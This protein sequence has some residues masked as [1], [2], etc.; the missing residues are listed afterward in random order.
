VAAAIDRVFVLLFCVLFVA[1]LLQMLTYLV[2]E[3]A[4]EERRKLKALPAPL[5][6]LTAMDRHLSD[7]V[8]G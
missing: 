8:N 6:R 3:P 2:P 5:S 1:P 4:V 7:D